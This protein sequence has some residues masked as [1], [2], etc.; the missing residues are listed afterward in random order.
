MIVYTIGHS[1]RTVEE[2]A[3]L[4]KA[5]GVDRLVD[6]RTVPRSR[7][8]PQFNKD[9]LPA[10]LAA[11]GIGYSH[12]RALG[13][14]RGPRKADGAPSPN[15]LWRTAGFRNYADYAMTGEFRAALDRLIALAGRSVPAIMCAEAVWWRCHRRLVAD[16]LL[17]RGIDVRHIM[18]PGKVEPARLTPGAVIGSDLTL[19]YPEAD[20]P[21]PGPLFDYGNDR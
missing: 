2:L 14:L 20:G 4:L 7:T 11:A 16:N 12:C 15:T 5:V 1:T 6:I 8:N 10:A 19:T 3:S 21:A 13:G 9:T 18:G 17:V